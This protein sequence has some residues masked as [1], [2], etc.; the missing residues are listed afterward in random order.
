MA[1]SSQDFD[2][3]QWLLGK[4]K[5]DKLSVSEEIELRGYIVQEFPQASGLSFA[6]LVDFGMIYVGMTLLV[7]RL[8]VKRHARN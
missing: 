2:R 1:L 7:E 8:S 6:N 3:M 4:S 5:L